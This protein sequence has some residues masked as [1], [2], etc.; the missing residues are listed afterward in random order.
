MVG[1]GVKKSYSEE[2]AFEQIPD[3]SEGA[4]LAAI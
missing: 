4:R 3:G 1:I 2:V